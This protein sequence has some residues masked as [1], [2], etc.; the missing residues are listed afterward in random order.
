MG[1]LRRYRAP[2]SG[3]PQNYLYGKSKKSTHGFTYPIPTLHHYGVSDARLPCTYLTAT[4]YH[5]RV[6]GSDLPSAPL[7]AAQPAAAFRDLPYRTTG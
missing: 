2:L 7:R 6:G 1:T 3:F 4:L 5:Y